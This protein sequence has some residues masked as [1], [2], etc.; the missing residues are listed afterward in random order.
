MDYLHGTDDVFRR[1]KCYDRNVVL[2]GLRS[3]REVFPDPPKHSMQ[4]GS[5]SRAV[6]VSHSS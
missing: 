4:N 6:E 3:A 5:T 1:S 2:F